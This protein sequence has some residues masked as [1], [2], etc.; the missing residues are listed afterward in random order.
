M[1]RLTTEWLTPI[2]GAMAEWDQKLV[3]LTGHNLAALACRACGS[4]E[5][6]AAGKKAAVIPITSGEGVIGRFA[7]SVAAILRTIGMDAA[8]TDTTDVTG[9]YEA[10][11][12]DVDLVFMADDDRYIA[13]SLKTGKVGE[14][15]LCTALGYR[16][17]LIE[18]NRLRNGDSL[19]GKPVLLMGYGRVGHIMY[20]L[21]KEIGTEV[22]V[23]DKDPEKQAELA[24]DDIPQI[25]DRKKIGEFRL[26]VDLTNEGDWLDREWLQ[27]EVIMAA[28][29]VPLSLHPED[30]AD[31]TERVIHDDLE[32]GTAVM[33]MKAL[34]DRA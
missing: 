26:I 1:T 18:C 32:I 29:G 7:E 10:V 6:M 3:S 9:L 25:R 34:G 17:L 11:N 19:K 24:R 28:P 16:Q 21:L 15:D 22:T 5:N 8:V 4:T 2:Q 30:A 14:N 12:K 13:L 20:R 27:N 23:F 31:F 33:A